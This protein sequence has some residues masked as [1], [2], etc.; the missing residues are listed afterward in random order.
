MRRYVLTITC[1]DR[2]GIVAAV[3]SHLASRGG[4]VTEAAQ[5]ADPETGRFFQRIEVLTE[6]LECDADELRDGFEPVVREFDL[7]LRISDTDHRKRV[8]L[9]VSKEDH[10]LADI[11]HRAE[12]DE[13]VERYGVPFVVVPVTPERRATAM[14]EIA[15]RIGEVEGEAVV[16]AR[17]MQ[18]L[19]PE[20]CETYRDRILNIHHS[21]LPSFAGP[22]PYHQAFERGVKLIGATCHYVTAELDSGPIIAQDTAPVGHA[23]SVEDMVRIGRDIER[24]VL[25]RGLRWHLEDRVLVNGSRTVVFA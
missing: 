6:S 14:S 17:Y 7:D 18:I 13:L 24:T 9:L 23:E 16:L 22:R 12:R 4:W 11:L 8:V 20:L 5:H 1:P 25:A 10:C 3:T 21:A 19:S 15:A 2:V